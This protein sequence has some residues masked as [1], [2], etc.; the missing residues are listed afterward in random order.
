[1]ERWPWASDTS[2]DERRIIR[3]RTRE[4][5]AAKKAQVRGPAAHLGYLTRWPPS[6]VPQVTRGSFEGSCQIVARLKGH[7]LPLK[8]ATI[9]RPPKIL[10]AL[11]ASPVLLDDQR[12]D[13]PLHHGHGPPRQ[14]RRKGVAQDSIDVPTGN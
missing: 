6:P 4:A 2:Q 5:L 12:C 8:A 13:L 11:S 3:Q 9:S 1:M 10:D 14:L 7:G